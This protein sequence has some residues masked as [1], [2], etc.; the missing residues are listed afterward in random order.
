MYRVN[1]KPMSVNDA[2]QGR[3]FKTKNYYKYCKDLSFVLPKIKVNDGSLE[4]HFIF[5]ITSC[6][7]IDNPI[8]LIIDIFQKKYHFDDK[9]VMKLIVE[10]KIVKKGSEYFEFKII[11]YL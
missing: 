11:P 6:S 5:G 8:K 3:R 2:W 1:L 9:N 10:K 7:D 4:I